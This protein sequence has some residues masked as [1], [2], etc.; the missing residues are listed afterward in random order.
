MINIIW[1]ILIGIGILIAAGTGKT[2]IISTSIF[3][4][5]GKAI[6][7]SIGLAGIMAF[8]SG[9]LKIAE[10]SGMTE[11]L[12]RL[13]QPIFAK[14]FPKIPKNHP[15]LGLISLTVSANFLGL[16]NVATP[17]GL[18]TMAEL[19]AL[20]PD[21]AQASDATCTFMALVFGSLSLIP[22]T[23]IAI[24]AQA[25]SNNPALVIVPVFII[26]LAGTLIGLL[27]NY[28]AIRLTRK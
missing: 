27:V 26:S 1:F 15:V 16:G 21:P 8:W 18:K 28:I 2:D 11:A 25:G 4:S 23:V 14:L 17:I 5:A 3:V 22:S 20:S 9:I 6:E 7:F 19:K 13:F 10:V 12:A 24:R